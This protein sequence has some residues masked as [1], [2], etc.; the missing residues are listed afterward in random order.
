MILWIVAF[1]SVMLANY[2]WVTWEMH[3]STN[4]MIES[5]F[6]SAIT[7]IQPG[8]ESNKIISQWKFDSSVKNRFY[9]GYCTYFAALITPEIFTYVAPNEQVSPIWGNAKERCE[10]AKNVWISVWTEAKA[11]ALV[12]YKWGTDG[13]SPY[14]HVG[15]V[16]YVNSEYNKMIVRD[17]NYIGKYIATDRREELD[18]EYIK[19]YIYPPKNEIQNPEYVTEDLTKPFEE[20]AI[21][22]LI[23]N[24]NIEEITI[25]S[26]EIDETIDILIEEITEEIPEVIEEVTEDVN[27]VL[28]DDSGIKLDT[29]TLSPQLTH[30]ISQYDLKISADN[31]SEILKWSNK[32]V[33]IEITKKWSNEK[34]SGIL[35]ESLNFITSNN[36]ID[37]D[38][39]T[40][41]L[42]YNW[43]AKVNISAKKSG[44][45]AVI[46][47]FWTSKIWVIKTTI[48]K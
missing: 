44:N 38:Y 29:S 6:Q 18:E 47:N 34:F 16:M 5:N 45:S 42:V 3:A 1:F 32:D 14:G 26:E 4:N 20:M 25:V 31:T 19:C 21:E 8:L 7:D 46:I 48:I 10:N 43:K 2:S 41:Q 22:E 30:F 24:E 28:V 39:S 40:I 11:W 12:I 35:P 36:K 23:A 37:L 15:R 13:I 33:I 17:G 9:P 27:V